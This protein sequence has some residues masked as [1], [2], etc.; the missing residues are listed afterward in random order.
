MSLSRAVLDWVAMPLKLRRHRQ[1]RRNPDDPR[2]LVIRRNRM[3]DM[4]YTLPLLHALRRHFP[5]AHLTV[6]CD[7]LGAPIAEACEA[8]NDVIVLEPGWNS[9]QAAFKNAARLQDYDWVI[10]AKGGFD[11]R[12]AVL[13]RLTNAAI[14]IGFERQSHRPSAYY[15]DP[16]ALPGGPQEEHQIDTLLRLLKPVGLVKPTGFTVDLSL[17]IPDSARE[18]A[19]EILARPPFASSRHFMLINLSSTVGLK[20]REEDFI[21]LAGRVLGS[22]DLVIGLIAAPLDQ[23]KAREIAL[24]MASKRIAAVDTPGPLDLAALLE[25]A[26]FLLTPE[27]GA[28]HLAAAV[29]TPALVLWSEGPFH[30][31]HS[32]G[33]KHAFVHA[34]PGESTIPVERVW[35]ALQPFL[36]PKKDGDD[37]I[38]PT[39]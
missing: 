22:T 18:F 29:G 31:W 23:Q 35:K 36:I 3:G 38:G 6:A 20:F 21:A 2:I 7:P 24:C 10:A 8:V 17:R 34:G 13:A 1:P 14:R 19:A 30:K 26:S 9:W 39:F 37:E 15:T 32:R 5:L 28:A 11:R 4:I 16:V 33:R 27:G 25:Q 12:L